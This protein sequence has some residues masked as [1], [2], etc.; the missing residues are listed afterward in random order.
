MRTAHR[1][2]LK[3]NLDN[4]GGGQDEYGFRHLGEPKGRSTEGELTLAGVLGEFF[5]VQPIWVSVFRVEDGKRVNILEVTG[6]HENLAMAEY[7]YAFLL[8]ASDALWKPA[9]ARSRHP[10]R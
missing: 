7:V 8:H 1:L 5:F 4:P 2:M 6:R 10:S 9:Q 3:H